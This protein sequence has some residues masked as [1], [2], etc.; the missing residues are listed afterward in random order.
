MKTGQWERET[1]ASYHF[2]SAVLLVDDAAQVDCILRGHKLLITSTI[3][4][5][6][7]EHTFHSAMSEVIESK[8]EVVGEEKMLEKENM[9]LRE[10]VMGTVPRMTTQ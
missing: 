3:N 7:S 4:T 9:F 5:I 2:A 1:S 10:H 8:E 6:I